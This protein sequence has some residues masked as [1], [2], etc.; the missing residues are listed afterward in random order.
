[1]GQFPSVTI[2]YTFD[3]TNAQTIFSEL[4]SS[5][6]N[7]MP[8]FF[9]EDC[10]KSTLTIEAGFYTASCKWYDHLQLQIVA[11]DATSCRVVVC[12]NIT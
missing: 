9:L 6:Q 10:N 4:V 1:M 2:E 11:N 5:L 8:G 12:K 7:P 3:A